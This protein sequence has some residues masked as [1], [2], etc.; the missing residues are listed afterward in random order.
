MQRKAK[1]AGPGEMAT[2]E[3]YDPFHKAFHPLLSTQGK[4]GDGIEKL[5]KMPL[6]VQSGSGF[7][8]FTEIV[9]AKRVENWYGVPMGCSIAHH[10][11]FADDMRISKKTR[12]EEEGEK[13][14]QRKK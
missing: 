2:R 7:I 1:G 12:Y 5:K 8:Y 10:K 9:L 11:S 13:K 14:I 3:I 4:V 6:E